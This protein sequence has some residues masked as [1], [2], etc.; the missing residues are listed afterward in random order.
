MTLA[1]A[2]IDPSQYR[3]DFEAEYGRLRSRPY[4]E[5]LDDIMRFANEIVRAYRRAPLSA[6]TIARQVEETLRRELESLAKSL[7]AP[8]GLGST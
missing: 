5:K 8:P 1:A 6:E 3:E 4:E 7:A 2:G